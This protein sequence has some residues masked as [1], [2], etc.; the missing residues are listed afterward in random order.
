MTRPFLGPS[1][2][3][4]TFLTLMGAFGLN[5]TGGQFFT[6]LSQS[7]NWD[8]TTLSLA[9]SL[10]MLTWGI[11]QP[12]MGRLIDRFG[13]KFV[14]TGS[15]LLMG[16]SFLLSSTITEVWQFFLYYGVFTGI[17]FAGCGSMA[18]S[19]LVS[20]WYVKKRPMMLARSSMG[21]NV[22]QLI[23]LPLTG[24]L[25][26]NTGFRSAFLVLGSF[27]LLI[28]V[29][30]ILLIV[31]SNPNEV[32]QN[33]DGMVE[34]YSAASLPKSISLP[35]ALNS[36]YF[37]T[38]TVGFMTCGYTLYLVT[39]HLPKY[40]F[41]LGG[42]TALGGQLLGLA[43]AASAVSM[44]FTGQLSKSLSKKTLLIGFYSLRAIAFIWLATSTQVEQLYLFA[45]VYGVSSFPII[46]LVT[47]LIGN[48]FGATAMGSILGFAWLVH[49]V[50]AAMGVFL[51][52]YL[53]SNSGNYHLAFWSCAVLLG[54]GTLVTLLINE[55][56]TILP[57]TQPS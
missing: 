32:G 45:I 25:I 44:W 10:N 54:M 3:G 36:S 38:T 24:M 13:A 12:V 53:R 28:V 22:G 43:A 29:P 46:P 34:S 14:L 9:V 18:N 1:V 37:W 20:Q 8:L 39:T 35:E 49:Q 40:A 17:G 41:D 57:S 47:S 48:R 21:I 30:S 55:Q 52:G 51:G 42:G 23:L 11:L 56:Q 33:P 26:A 50:A 6:P 2:V 27:M 16:V 4:V 19:V 5:L 31:K 7:Y 15:A